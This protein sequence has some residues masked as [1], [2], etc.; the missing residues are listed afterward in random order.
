MN[1]QGVGLI[2][3]GMEGGLYAPT[4]RFLCIPAP[5]YTLSS[6]LQRLSIANTHLRPR[7][8]SVP[9][10]PRPVRGEHRLRLDPLDP[11]FPLLDP[12]RQIP[13]KKVDE[14]AAHPGA[15]PSV[16]AQRRRDAFHG[17]D[18]RGADG[19][20]F[21]RGVDPVAAAAAAAWKLDARLEQAD[22]GGRVGQQTEVVQDLWDAVVREHRELGDPAREERV[23]VRV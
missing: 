1:G 5:R 6:V 23:R 7:I 21:P 12:L 2:T 11:I 9:D 15:S 17:D 22:E 18:R 14:H 8:R 3:L 19:H 16:R 4:V 10:A 20:L 13:K